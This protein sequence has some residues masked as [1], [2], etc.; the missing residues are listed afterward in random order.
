MRI[1]TR[2]FLFV[3]SVLL[4]SCGAVRRSAVS[5]G[6]ITLSVADQRK[7]EYYFLEALKLEKLE[8]YDEAFEML[9]HCLSICPTGPSAQSKLAN[10]YFAFNKKEKALEALLCAVE[11]EP[12]NYWYHQTLAGYYQGN[13]EYDKAIAVIEEMQ[14]RFSKRNGELLPALVGLYGYTGQ[15]DKVID[16]LARLEVIAGKSEAISMEKVRNYLLMGDAEK[17]FG[18]V[19][20][21]VAEYPDDAY[22]RVILAEVYMDHGRT[23]EAE[24]ILHEILAEDPDNAPAKITLTEYYK[25]QADTAHYLAMAESVVMSAE[26]NEDLKVRMMAQLIKEDADSVWVMDV[27]E[28][29]MALPQ[30]SA[31]LGYLCVQYMLHLQQ[32]EERVRPVLLRMLEVEPDHIPARSQLLFYASQRNDVEE[33]VS[34]CSEGIDYSPE[35]LEYYYY[36]GI[37]LCYYMNRPEEALEIYRQATRQITEKSDGKMASDIYTEMGNLLQDDGREDE[38]SDCYESALEYNP[39]NVLA[40]N[41][42]AY[43]LA[44]AGVNL[45]RAEQMSWRA[46][47]AEPDNATYLDTYAWVLYKLQR[48]DEALEYIERALAIETV[49]SD[50]LY[51]HAGDICHGLGDTV[52]ALD[53]WRKALALQREG[54]MVDKDLEMKIK[55]V[56]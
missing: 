23:S 48:Y 40:L 33:M 17:A 22:Y 37:G 29:A 19:E 20:A 6:E 34:I 13:R 56:R 50:V 51:E 55:G 54:G 2:Y 12:D 10:Y 39:N 26:V 45:E 14:Q 41:N 27:F 11:G 43:L 46:I 1:L 15:Y 28:R 52:Q 3:I 44:E 32:P 47:G 42:Y 35:V 21:L 7:Y 9:Q 36:K 4:A 30:Q 18:E 24:R 8:R 53:Y 5:G 16:A 25:Q 38:A 49:P 31:R